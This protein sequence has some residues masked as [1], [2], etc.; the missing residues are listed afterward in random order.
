MMINY[1]SAVSL[2]LN[3]VSMSFS[4]ETDISL[5]VGGTVWKQTMFTV[6]RGMCSTDPPNELRH[7][8]RS[9][10][11]CVRSCTGMN[12]CTSVNWKMPS[13]CEMFLLA[14]P[15]NFANISDC[16]FLSKGEL[17][18]RT[19]LNMPM[20]NYN[21]NNNTHLFYMSWSPKIQRH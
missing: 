19:I 2:A 13:T 9:R 15:A 7:N 10:S 5:G 14:H 8:I 16:T 21:N 17:R 1:I 11:G 12:G 20:I 4:M 6:Q 18:W 3:L